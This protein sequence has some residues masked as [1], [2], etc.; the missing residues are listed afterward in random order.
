MY[1]YSFAAIRSLLWEFAAGAALPGRRRWQDPCRAKRLARLRHNYRCCNDLQQTWPLG[2]VDAVRPNVPMRSTTDDVCAP[3]PS[4]WDVGRL[5]SV[6]RRDID[7]NGDQRGHVTAIRRCGDTRTSNLSGNAT[8][9]LWLSL[10]WLR[11]GLGIRGEGISAGHSAQ[12]GVRHRSPLVCVAFELDGSAWRSDRRNE[13][14]FCSIDLRDAGFLFPR[15][16]HAPAEYMRPSPG[17]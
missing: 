15:R 1:R 9:N 4:A 10:E 13:E 2:Q 7:A 14:G 8:N 5:H 17:L 6:E 12:S 11:L 3:A 16:V